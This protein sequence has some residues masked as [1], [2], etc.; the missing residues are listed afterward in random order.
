MQLAG[1]AF[2]QSCHLQLSLNKPSYD[3]SDAI[4]LRY[5][6]LVTK[7]KAYSVLRTLYGVRSQQC[8]ITSSGKRIDRKSG[9][10]QAR[11]T[12]SSIIYPIIANI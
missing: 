2:H 10:S 5:L 3:A 8:H 1:T 9:I 7:I 12:K 6:R 11:R 4:F